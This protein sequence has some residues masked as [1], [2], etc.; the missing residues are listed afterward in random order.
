MGALCSLLIHDLAN[1]LCV[2]SGNASFA[3]FSPDDP[4]QLA[5]ALNAIVQ[6]GEQ[7]SHLLEQCGALR[8]RI[9][10]HVKPGAVAEI[11]PLLQQIQT[12]H[13][14]WSLEVAPALSGAVSAPAGWVAFTVAQLVAATGTGVGAV[15]LRGVAVPSSGVLTKPRNLPPTSQ[16]LEFNLTYEAAGAFP[17]QEI[18]SQHSNLPLLSAVELMKNLGGRL[19]HDTSAPGRQEV[20]LTLPW[21]P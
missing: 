20:T 15:R 21:V 16:G 13:P 1:Q 2:I 11:L 5:S 7:A 12:A 9:V 19:D 8:H 18:R 6:S 4:R 14:Q 3:Q 17:F 10:E